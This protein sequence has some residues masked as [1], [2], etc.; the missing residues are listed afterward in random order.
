MDP[1]VFLFLVLLF[2]L[3]E[4]RVEIRTTKVGDGKNFCKLIF[5]L[6]YISCTCRISVN[7]FVRYCLKGMN[8]LR[9]KAI[10]AGML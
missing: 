3:S 1:P 9:H 8:R 7:T 6:T 5:R 4:G 2:G 10:I